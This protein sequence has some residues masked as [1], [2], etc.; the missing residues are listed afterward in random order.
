MSTLQEGWTGEPL[1]RLG[2]ISSVPIGSIEDWLRTIP[3]IQKSGIAKGAIVPVFYRLNGNVEP[4]ASSDSSPLLLLVSDANRL[5]AINSG[6]SSISKNVSSI[7]SMLRSLGHAHHRF[8]P[9]AL[10]KGDAGSTRLS[11]ANLV[12]D[13]FLGVA[14]GWLMLKHQQLIHEQCLSVARYLSQA[15]IPAWIKWLMG[16]PAGLKLNSNLS[17]FL[18]DLFL[19]LLEIWTGL[20]QE[21]APML[22]LGIRATAMAGIFGLSSL[23]AVLDVLLLRPAFFYLTAFY[24]LATKLYA[25]EVRCL[26]SLWNLFRGKKWNILH[27]RLDSA[28]YTLD[29]LLLGTVFFTV[30]TF[31]LPTISVYYVL[32]VAAQVMMLACQTGI[33]LLIQAVLGLPIKPMVNCLLS[34]NEGP[35]KVWLRPVLVNGESTAFVSDDLRLE[36]HDLTSGQIYLILEESSPSCL[37]FVYAYFLGLARIL[38][39]NFGPSV[40]ASFIRG[41]PVSSQV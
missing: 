1:K 16:W 30:L 38:G 25:S 3:K 29:Q 40:W 7:G 22:S 18:G 23:L 32:F 36:E 14:S 15:L 27:N 17:K 8:S 35:R 19:W 26:V 20:T 2:T 31:L 24:F 9:V 37:P 10:L 28:D 21:A 13:V 12:L 41:Q 34:R 6:A 4:I 33:A 5:W 11:S 39:T